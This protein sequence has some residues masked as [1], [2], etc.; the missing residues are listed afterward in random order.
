MFADP[1]LSHEKSYPTVLLSC[2]LWGGGAGCLE[3]WTSGRLGK[4]IFIIPTWNQPPLPL[5]GPLF[6]SEVLFPLKAPNH[7]NSSWDFKGTQWLLAG[8][9][10][11]PLY[12]AALKLPSPPGTDRCLNT[13]VSCRRSC[14][15]GFQQKGGFWLQSRRVIKP[16]GPIG[17]STW[18]GQV[19]AGVTVL[20]Q[21]SEL[22]T[23][24]HY[25]IS[26]APR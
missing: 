13:I 16:G 23:H 25:L 20:L 4:C 17:E 24:R 15:V 9:F 22:G 5:P 2:W 19:E 26:A 21:D 10:S 7:C 1:A 14:P 18:P 3:A 11:L 8:D 6:P 12:L